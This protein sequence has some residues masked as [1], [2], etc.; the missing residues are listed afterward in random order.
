MRACRAA[1]KAGVPAVAVVSTGFLRQ[2][3]ATARALGIE[4]VRIAEYPGI[5]PVDSLPVLEEK[6]RTAVVPSILEV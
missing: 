3:R 2:A 1:E 6:V 4:G 5:V